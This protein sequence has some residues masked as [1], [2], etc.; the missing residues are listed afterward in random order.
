MKTRTLRN[1]IS[2]A[3]LVAVTGASEWAMAQDTTTTDTVTQGRAPV[4]EVP[5]KTH[6]KK[7]TDKSAAPAATNLQTVT[8]TGT[9]IRGGASPSPVITIGSEQ[10]QQEGFADLGEVIRSVP[11]NFSGGQ[12]PGVIPFTISG[13]GGQN[14]NITGGSALNLRGLGQDASLTLLN[15][16]RMAYGGVSQ[17]VDI[18]AIP[19]QAVERIEIVPDGASAI[20]GS[21]AVGGVANVVLRRSFDG[22]SVSARLG[23]ATDGGLTTR[24]YAATAGTTWASGGLIATVEDVATDPI[25]ARQRAYTA[26][27]RDPWTLYPK[28]NQRSALFSIHQQL[29]DI[30]ELSLDAFRTTRAQRYGVYNDLG[31]Q[32][33]LAAPDT[34]TWLASPSVDFFLPNDWTLS[35]SGAWAKNRHEQYQSLERLATGTISV[36]DLCV[37]SESRIVELSAEGPLFTL[38]AGEARLAVGSGHRRNDFLEY[39]HVARAATIDGDE[40][41]R[42]AYAELNL[43]LLGPRSSTGSAGRLDLSL[44]LR[45]EDYESFG[46]VSIPKLGV[47]Y[48]P[49]EDFTLKGSWG[50]SFKTPTLYQ[51]LR[52][53]QVV[54]RSAQGSGGVGFPPNATVLYLDGGNP[55]LEPERARTWTASIAFHPEALPGLETELTYFD[56][57]YTGRVVQPITDP[58]QALSNPAYAEFIQ[59]FPSPGEQAAIIARDGDGVITNQAGS[60]YDPNNVVGVVYFHFRNA[61]AQRIR[62]L[63]L[64]SSY[65]FDLGGSQLTFRGSASWLDSTQ[66][67]STTRFDLAGTLFNPPTFAGRFGAVWTAGALTASTFVNHK[68]GLR[69]VVANEQTASFTTVDATMRY[70][71]KAMQDASPEW[72]IALSLQNAFNR[73]PPLHTTS[74]V[75]PFQVPPYDATN[76]SPIGRFVSVSVTRHW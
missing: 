51:L 66:Q 35:V 1:A 24:E 28:S 61:V 58:T 13:A 21:D 5:A 9:R 62:G 11:Q 56:I 47:V 68:S 69:N 67:F 48:R 31:N 32:F 3:L 65:R 12:N 33:V 29:G 26:Y 50:K 27:L 22:A 59:M 72:E 39:N 34:M 49:S 75:T 8:V 19:V 18:S 63:D 36:T 37:C 52:S 17:G 38:P 53:E 40:A 73:A 14:Q 74:T 76:F 15:G 60:P 41:S 44:A 23:G 16:H 7:S 71:W 6:Q 30:A 2:I 46:R 64:S 55:E 25:Y 45:G 42:F 70:A 54:L 20:Y 4:T 10:I 57:D 43:P